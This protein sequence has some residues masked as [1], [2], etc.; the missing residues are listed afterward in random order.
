M[1]F[2]IVASISLVIIM[3]VFTTIVDNHEHEDEW[4]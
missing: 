4:L 1:M 3:L 2:P